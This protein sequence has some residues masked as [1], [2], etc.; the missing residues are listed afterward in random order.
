MTNPIAEEKIARA[1]KAIDDLIWLI[2]WREIT[3]IVSDVAHYEILRMLR[4]YRFS[5]SEKGATPEAS[6]ERALAYIDGIRRAYQSR[7]LSHADQP[8]NS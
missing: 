4:F 2:E 3:L 7:L 8:E 6:A 5:V 1:K